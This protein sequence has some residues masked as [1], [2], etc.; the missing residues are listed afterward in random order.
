MSRYQKYADRAASEKNVTFVG[1]I[2]TYRYYNVD[3]VV[4]ATLSEFD[5]IPIRIS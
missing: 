1:R 2:A 4:G 5:R 3:Q